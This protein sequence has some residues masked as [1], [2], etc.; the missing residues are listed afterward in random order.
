MK[1]RAY[2][3][4]LSLSLSPPLSLS[5]S[6]FQKIFFSKFQNFK[7]K[8]QKEGIQTKYEIIRWRKRW[9]CEGKFDDDVF[10][11]KE[12]EEEENGGRF[13]ESEL[14]IENVV[15]EKIVLYEQPVSNS[16]LDIKEWYLDFVGR[17]VLYKVLLSEEFQKVKA[18]QREC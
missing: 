11:W 3:S 1:T 2:L 8:S 13:Q 12:Q 18:L 5:L 16:E 6:L 10:F 15:V 17:I 7:K 9:I 4:P 14:D